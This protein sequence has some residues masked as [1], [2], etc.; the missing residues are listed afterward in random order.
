MK[1]SFIDMDEVISLLCKAEF[2]IFHEESIL[3]L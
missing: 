1:I 2:V 3:I